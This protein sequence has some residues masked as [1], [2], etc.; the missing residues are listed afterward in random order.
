MTRKIHIPKKE[1][2]YYYND[3]GWTQPRIAAHYGCSV[4]TISNLMRAYGL[5]TRTS[6]DYTRIDLPC[7]ELRE[8][9]VGQQLTSEQ[10]AAR[11][12]CAPSTVRKHLR[13]CGI[14]LRPGGLPPQEYVPASVLEA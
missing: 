3:L 7:A 1:L 2:D 5:P 13:D 6:Q 11:K 10:I 9:Y 12:G 8:L 14:P 4:G